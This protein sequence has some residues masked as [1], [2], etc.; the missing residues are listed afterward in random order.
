MLGLDGI[1]RRQVFLDPLR[2]PVQSLPEVLAKLMPRLGREEEGECTA[3]QRAERERPD[4]G[5]RRVVGVAL[6]QADPVE[7]LI[8]FGKCASQLLGEVLESHWY[9][10]RWSNA[11]RTAAAR[12]L[13]AIARP[14]VTTSS[15]TARGVSPPPSPYPSASARPSMRYGAACAS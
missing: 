11:P 5:E 13:P 2:R 8:P 15:R 12:T 1:R 7:Q 6:L 14:P 4:H 10:L 9:I 3:D